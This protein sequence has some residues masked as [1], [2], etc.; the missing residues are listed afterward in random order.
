MAESK[1]HHKF[2]MTDYAREIRESCARILELLQVANPVHEP[3]LTTSMENS[4]S[5]FN[6]E[7][8]ALVQK[9]IDASESS[10]EI[11]ASEMMSKSLPIAGEIHPS[12]KSIDEHFDIDESVC[13]ENLMVDA[14]MRRSDLNIGITTTGL[15]ESITSTTI[16]PLSSRMILVMPLTKLLGGDLISMGCT[17]ASMLL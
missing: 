8:V 9:E 17:R 12:L 3:N 7:I 14:V 10:M 2:P 1:G 6:G 4:T 15:N 16:Q 13:A 11:D 5:D